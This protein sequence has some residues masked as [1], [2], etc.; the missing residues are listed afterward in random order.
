MTTTLLALLLA[1][2]GP[3][4]GYGE[5]KGKA[6]AYEGALAPRDLNTLVEA[7]QQALEAAIKACGTWSPGRLPFTIVIAVRADGSVERSWRNA[8]DPYI[9]CTVRQVIAHTYP[10]ATGKPFNASFELN[11]AD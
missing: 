6:D 11:F 5:A 3:T 2:A 8:D 10:V 7:Q 1:M 9:D 4:P